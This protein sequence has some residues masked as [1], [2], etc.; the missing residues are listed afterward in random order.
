MLFG[1]FKLGLISKE[2]YS[3]Q[4]T[5]LHVKLADLEN[6]MSMMRDAIVSTKLKGAKDSG[7]SKVN[8][9]EVQLEETPVHPAMAARQVWI[10]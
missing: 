6:D 5:N 2:D 7:T 10:E 1:E 8:D 4:H 3:A 9:E